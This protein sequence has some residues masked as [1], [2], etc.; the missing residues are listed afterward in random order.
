MIFEANKKS[1][2]LAVVLIDAYNTAKRYNIRLLSEIEGG[3]FS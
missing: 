1:E 2:A 3:G